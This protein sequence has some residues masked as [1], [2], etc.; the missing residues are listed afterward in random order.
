VPAAF[1]IK[2]E[3]NFFFSS[4]ESSQV[5]EAKIGSNPIGSTAKNKG[6]KARK[7]SCTINTN[8][9]KFPGHYNK[10]LQNTNTINL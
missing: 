3:M 1:V 8:L 9:F 4:A 6:T 10:N 5:R 7:I 2:L